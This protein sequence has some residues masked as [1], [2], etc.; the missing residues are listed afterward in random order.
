[1]DAAPG[2]RAVPSSPRGLSFHVL[3]RLEEYDGVELDVGPRKQ[4]AVRS[5]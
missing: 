1:V 4:R 3:G 5:H 2:L